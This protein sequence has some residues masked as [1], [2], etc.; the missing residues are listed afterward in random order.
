MS[1]EHSPKIRCAIYTRKSTDDGLDQD[2]NSL[3]AQREAGEAFIASQKNEG[4][5]FLPDHY[6][7]GGFTGGNIERPGLQRLMD[8]IEKGLV[9]CV[10]VYTLRTLDGPADVPRIHPVDRGRRR[11]DTGQLHPWPAAPDPRSRS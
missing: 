5:V 1:R 9:D 7:D 2:F 3:D 4:W 11:S 10:V 8:D 6:D